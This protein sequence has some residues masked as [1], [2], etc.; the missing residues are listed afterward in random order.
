M[1]D[2]ELDGVQDMIRR[3]GATKAQVHDACGE[4]LFRFGSKIMSISRA[5]Y[6]PYKTHTLQKSGMAHEPEWRG[7]TATVTLSYGGPGIPYA[8]IQHERT[9]FHHPHGQAK[10]LE[11][12]VKRFGTQQG[13]DTY[14]APPI[15]RALNR[16]V[17][18][19]A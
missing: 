11:T 4:G 7:D 16:G 19:N 10:Y 14:L 18:G 3:L 6:V 17:L 2:F 13:V 12:P 1:A 5:E 15:R 8:L 9:D